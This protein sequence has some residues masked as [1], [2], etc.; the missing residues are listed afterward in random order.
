VI[1]AY[2]LREEVFEGKI[3]TED[4]HKIY[5]ELSSLIGESLQEI[6]E[7]V[8]V[9]ALSLETSEIKEGVVLPN[10]IVV[11]RINGDVLIKTEAM[12]YPYQVEISTLTDHPTRLSEGLSVAKQGDLLKVRVHIEKSLGGAPLRRDD[13]LSRRSLPSGEVSMEDFIHLAPEVVEFYSAFLR[14]VTPVEEPWGGKRPGR[15]VFVEGLSGTGKSTSARH[16]GKLLGRI[17]YYQVNLSSESKVSDISVEYRFQN[18]KVSMGVKDLFKRLGK[19]NGQRLSAGTREDGNMKILVIDETNAQPEVLMPLMPLLQ[20]RRRFG[21]EMGREFF[22]VELDEDVVVVLTFNPAQ[23]FSGR[24]DFPPELLSEGVKLSMPDPV[25]FSDE[26]LF[27]LFQELSRREHDPR[28]MARNK[29]V[30]SIVQSGPLPA[31]YQRFDLH[32]VE[33]RDDL[34]IPAVGTLSGVLES[35]GIEPKEGLP[36]DELGRDASQEEVGEVYDL[37]YDKK[38]INQAIEEIERSGKTDSFA[39][40]DKILRPYLLAVGHGDK[41]GIEED[42]ILAMAGMISP[43]LKRAVE[44]IV[45]V[46]EQEETEEEQ[47]REILRELRRG[48]AEGGYFVSVQGVEVDNQKKQYVRLQWVGAIRGKLDGVDEDFLA[49]LVEGA[50]AERLAAWLKKGNRFQSLLVEGRHPEI[51]G[52]F[53]GEYTVVYSGTLTPFDW[54]YWHETGHQFQ[55]VIGRPSLN[56]N[57]ELYSSLFPLMGVRNPKAYLRKLIDQLT[58]VVREKGAAYARDDYYSQAAKGILNGFRI[59]LNEKKGIEGALL[60][61]FDERFSVN[62]VEALVKSIIKDLSEQE[63]RQAAVRFFKEPKRY[64]GTAKAGSYKAEVT[65]GSGTGVRIHEVQGHLE[66]R[67][68]V[69]YIKKEGNR[70]VTKT[71][72]KQGIDKHPEKGR[73]TRKKEKKTRR[74]ISRNIQTEDPNGFG[75]RIRSIIKIRPDLVRRFVSVFAVPAMVERTLSDTGVEIDV[76]E[77]L[78]NGM[79]FFVKERKTDDKG[80][81]SAGI[82]LD[83]SGS[84]QE[85]E[86]L[87][88]ALGKMSEAMVSLLYLAAVSNPDVTYSFGTVDD[89]YHGLIT[90]PGQARSLEAVDAALER[91]WS[92]SGGTF[93]NK[94]FEAIEEKYKNSIYRGKQ[95]K[96]EFIVVDGEDNSE[97]GMDELIARRKEVEEAVPGL[98]IVFIGAGEKAVKVKEFGKFVYF[99]EEPGAEELI[100]A[101]IRLSLEKVRRQGRLPEE[102]LGQLA[103]IEKEGASSP[104]RVRETAAPGGIDLTGSRQT[105]EVK[106]E[107]A[108][109]PVEKEMTFPAGVVELEALGPRFSGFSFQILSVSPVKM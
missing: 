91:M 20:G 99:P 50:E 13:T 24:K 77:M 69:K 18:G 53:E 93:Y 95:N 61:D 48:I 2:F 30:K 31:G 94:A 7:E 1:E 29:A 63:I 89:S 83:S 86:S 51:A 102:D 26:T 70:S 36:D 49:G 52:F 39:F 76:M 100:E 82:H 87:Q 27:D 73:I 19:V 107:G 33:I 106:K 57:V 66:E 65:L 101:V 46:Y 5:T 41:E 67:P 81:L 68:V 75:A 32:P 38:A 96:L 60:S 55:Q 74:E 85:N 25:D 98:D 109:S 45:R 92:H 79:E 97:M 23:L 14:A 54:V 9:H 105:V 43:R 88:K 10:G 47:W 8:V 42:K 59:Y 44:A 108:F 34:E 104:I 90:T 22:N 62:R 103:G 72:V 17:P 80:E 21:F 84:V 56:K 78:T 35:L 28:K 64:L 71:T 58:T 11:R 40:F 4:A 16:I 12:P 6:E 3:S 37:T 15:V